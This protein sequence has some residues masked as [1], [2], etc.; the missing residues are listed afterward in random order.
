MLTAQ[1]FTFPG[2]N[3]SSDNLSFKGF[4]DLEQKKAKSQV[5]QL[6]RKAFKIPDFRA[7]CCEACFKAKKL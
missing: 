7:T 5:Y 2:F 3:S 4:Q 1:N 6:G